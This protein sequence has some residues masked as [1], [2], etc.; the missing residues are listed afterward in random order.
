MRNLKVS[1]SIKANVTKREDGLLVVNGWNE[2]MEDVKLVM[3]EKQF[4]NAC[5]MYEAEKE[6]EGGDVS[7]YCYF[8]ECEVE[9]D[10]VI[11]CVN[12]NDFYVDMCYDE[13]INAEDEE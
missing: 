7:G 4:E 13:D 3:T 10:N 8:K 1:F 11:S 5:E 2:G 12:S 9:A 6:E